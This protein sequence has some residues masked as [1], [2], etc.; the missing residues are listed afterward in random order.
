MYTGKYRKSGSKNDTEIR[1]LRHEV[2]RYVFTLLYVFTFYRRRH[3]DTGYNGSDVVIF[4][5]LDAVG[6]KRGKN[7]VFIAKM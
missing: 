6:K 4:T 7:A 3:Y 2:E 5:C 1:S